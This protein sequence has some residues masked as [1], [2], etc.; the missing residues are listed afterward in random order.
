V[1]GRAYPPARRL[2]SSAMIRVD[3]TLV[4]TASAPA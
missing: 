2:T 1:L 4:S 3:S